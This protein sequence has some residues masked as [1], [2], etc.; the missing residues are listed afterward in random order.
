MKKNHL[1][2]IFMKDTNRPLTY[3]ISIKLIIFIL[4]LIVGSASTYA[5]FI[6]GYYSL[7]RDNQKLEQI[8]RSMKTEIGSLQSTINRLNK[9]RLAEELEGEEPVLTGL[10]QDTLKSADIVAIQ[11]LKLKIDQNV[12]NLSFSFILD[13]IVDDGQLVRGYVFIALK[14]SR[15]NQ[16]LTSFPEVNYNEGRPVDYLLGDRFAIRRF[17]GYRGELKLVKEADMFE[18]LVYS[19]LG[20]LLSQLRK[21]ISS[22]E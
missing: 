8:I 9:E 11:E 17:K 13:K 14:N 7:Y 12:V 22:I 2:I 21:N 19:D 6:K 18:I 15:T 10:E 5:F 4:V 20:K 1:T 3:E 16:K